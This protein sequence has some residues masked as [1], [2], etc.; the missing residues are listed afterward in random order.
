MNNISI[1]VL[2]LAL[3]IIFMLHDFEEIIM[4]NVWQIKYSKLLEEAEYKPFC[5]WLSTASGTVAVLVQFILFLAVSTISIIVNNYLVWYAL[6]FIVTAHFLLHYFISIRFHNYTPGLTTAI[7]FMPM[8]LFILYISAKMVIYKVVT[9]VIACMIA[10]VLF[11]PFFKWI[12]KKISVFEK[13][14][15]A[16]ANHERR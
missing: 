7:I 5:H 8:C 13:W 6:F 2:S 3:P 10:L 16:Y 9:L 12:T 4:V 15:T 1:E 14:L 11:Y